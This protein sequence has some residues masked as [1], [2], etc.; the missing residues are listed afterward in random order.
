MALYDDSSD[1]DISVDDLDTIAKMAIAHK[2]RVAPLLVEQAKPNV[3]GTLLD[4][5]VGLGQT[6]VGRNGPQAMREA[7]AARAAQNIN[8]IRALDY[9][10]V[11]PAL[12][13]LAEI[14]RRSNEFDERYKFMRDKLASDYQNKLDY[15]AAQ[16]ANQKE[17]NQLKFDNQKAL[18]D[19]ANQF[20]ASQADLQRQFLDNQNQTKADLQKQL[21]QDRLQSQKEM[22]GQRIGSQEGMLQN[23]LGL[24]EK[25]FG[26]GQ[27]FKGS[28]S[29]KQR[30]FLQEMQKERLEWQK[31]LEELRQ[32]GALKRAMIPKPSRS[33]GA[34]APSKSAGPGGG[35][36]LAPDKIINLSDAASIP[37]MIQDLRT[38]IMKNPNKF[39][40]VM[41][42]VFSLNPYDET[43]KAIESFTFNA[44]QTIGKLKEGGVLRAED[45]RKYAKML[46]LLS[47]TP[48]AALDKLDGLE[49]D[50]VKKYN[51]S[52]DALG[53]SG[54]D[55]SGLP[56]SFNVPSIPGVI[57][58]GGEPKSSLQKAIEAEKQKRGLK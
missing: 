22:Q 6:I 47:D 10:D 44:K 26:Q 3:L 27:E 42:R 53:K 21:Q 49:R 24:Q 30:Q 56:K 48:E 51:A 14:R 2:K 36:M 39:G 40:P 25:L 32:A 23:K 43:A 29:E 55:T 20:K 1:E 54:Y 17:L 58:P 46:P 15:L 57:N 7:Q 52:V 34:K 35:K 4:M 12:A 16:G 37:Q 18:S 50:L 31:T 19:L 33:A 45:E 41:G 5:G 13:K 38:I 9:G 8:A 11:T 28:E